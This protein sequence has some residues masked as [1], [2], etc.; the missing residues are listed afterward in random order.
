M[1]EIT[2]LGFLTENLSV[3]VYMEYPKNPDERFVVL[4]KGNSSREN[5]LYTAMFVADS[6]ADSLLDAAMLNQQVISALDRLTEL[7]SVSSSEHGGDYPVADI[8]NNKYRY[9]AVRN[10][11]HY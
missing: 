9:Q 2:V 4:K 3:P 11:T 5:F 10:I 1:I 6:Y 7:D 8:K